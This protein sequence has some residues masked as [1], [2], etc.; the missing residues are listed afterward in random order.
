MATLLTTGTTSPQ[1]LACFNPALYYV[2][3]AQISTGSSTSYRA[4]LVLTASTVSTA[5]TLVI[6]GQTFVFTS[7]PTFGEL[8]ISGSNLTTAIKKAIDSNPFLNYKIDT[9]LINSGLTITSKATG[10]LNDI[11]ISAPSSFTLSFTGGT[12]QYQGQ[13]YNNYK[14]YLEVWVSPF[15][16]YPTQSFDNYTNKLIYYQDYNDTNE[17]YFDIENVLQAQHTV[18]LPIFGTTIADR[19]S[20]HLVPFKLY[21]GEEYPDSN[22]FLI[23]NQLGEFKNQYSLFAAL[24]LNSNYNLTSYTQSSNSQFLTNSPSNKEVLKNQHEYLYFMYS[25]GTGSITLT[26]NEGL[27]IQNLSRAIKGDGLFYVDVSPQTLNIPTSASTYSV[28]L[29]SGA[30][31]LTV[32][33]SYKYV[34]DCN[35]NYVNLIWLNPLGGFDSYTFR[36]VLSTRL[37]RDFESYTQPLGY[38]PIP[39]DRVE[40]VQ[41]ATSDVETTVSARVPNSGTYNWLL[42][43]TR[44]SYVY[45][46]Q[47]DNSFK[48]VVITSAESEYNSKDNQYTLKITYRNTVDSNSQNG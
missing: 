5:S 11:S 34:N 9:V 32:S 21:W 39:S 33:K 45:E 38:N 41:F 8:P 15:D 25:A 31:P 30:T 19:V 3:T 46:V 18:E 24:P 43:L 37:T 35:S 27:N 10:S 7:T 6:D 48:Y 40:T 14:N 16:T 36:G 28:R 47:S 22:G 44:S 23:Q 4:D 12:N 13:S 20:G 42:E 17:I 2:E 26:V 29:Y 1:L